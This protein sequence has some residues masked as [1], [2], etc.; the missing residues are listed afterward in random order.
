M[1]QSGGKRDRRKASV[2][3]EDEAAEAYL[4]GRWAAKV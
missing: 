3:A 2:R 4:A 1:F